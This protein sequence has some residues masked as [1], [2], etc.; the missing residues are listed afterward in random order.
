MITEVPSPEPFVGDM[1]LALQRV[2]EASAEMVIEEIAE[3]GEE[4]V[5]EEVAVAGAETVVEES[6]ESSEEMIFEETVEVSEG[7]V[8]EKIADDEVL[9]QSVR[10]SDPTAPLASPPEGL[11]LIL[12]VPPLRLGRAGRNNEVPPVVPTKDP[13]PLL[14]LS[15]L[16]PD[17]TAQTK[18]VETET[19]RGTPPPSP[20]IEAAAEVEPTTPAP[21]RTPGEEYS[22]FGTRAARLWVRTTPPADP[23]PIRLARSFLHGLLHHGSRSNVF[24]LVGRIREAHEAL[25]RHLSQKLTCQ[26]KTLIN[27]KPYRSSICK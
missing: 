17:P 4:M 10:L 16:Q 22:S 15:P 14:E 13:Q 9:D 19:A 18:E 6:A 21:T 23:E 7:T 5:I 25:D 27:N 26:I 11:Q 1:N 24:D 12:W 20:E 2:A 8:I 3:A